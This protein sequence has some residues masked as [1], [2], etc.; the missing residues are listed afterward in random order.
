MKSHLEL[1]RLL[2]LNLHNKHSSL[3]G[4]YFDISANT[5]SD[6]I[7]I[8]IV[9]EKWFKKGKLEKDFLEPFVKNRY[10]GGSKKFFPFSHLKHR[11]SPLMLVIMKYFTCEGRYSRLYTYHVRLMNFTGVKVLKFPYYIYMSMEK[12]SSVV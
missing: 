3:A 4:V 2:I 11:F 12:M 7:G 5:I 6:G 8:P 9:G 1:T 10:R